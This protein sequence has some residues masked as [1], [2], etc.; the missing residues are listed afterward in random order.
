MAERLWDVHTRVTLEF[1]LHVYAHASTSEAADAQVRALLAEVIE[2][3]D[4]DWES[5][6]IEE[7]NC[8]YDITIDE[9]SEA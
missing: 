8:A 9:V 5:N 7:T 3:F 2:D 6:D 1:T 4:M